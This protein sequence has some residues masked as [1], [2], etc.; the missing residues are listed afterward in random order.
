MDCI[1]ELLFLFVYA[2]M[3]MGGVGLCAL[4]LDCFKMLL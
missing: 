4:F 3:F 1:L 2:T